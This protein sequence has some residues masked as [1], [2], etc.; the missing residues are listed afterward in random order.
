MTKDVIYLRHTLKQQRKAI[1]YNH[2]ENRKQIKMF[3]WELFFKDM[4]GVRLDVLRIVAILS[5]NLR[6]VD[7]TLT[8]G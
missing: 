1:L 5:A 8:A 4:M 6:S 7:F 3:L 2:L